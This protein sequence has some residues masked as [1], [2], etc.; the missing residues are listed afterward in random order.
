MDVSS[1]PTGPT[2]MI[3]RVY[4]GAPVTTGYRVSSIK[5]EK[6]GENEAFPV[7]RVRTLAQ[8]SAGCR[9][10]GG[11]FGHMCETPTGAIL[12]PQSLS[13]RAGP[14]STEYLKASKQAFGQDTGLYLDMLKS[15][16]KTKRG[17]M[18]GIMYTPVA[19]SARLVATP[20]WF[21]RDVVFVS[22]ELASTI[23]FCAHAVSKDG[24]PEATYR[25]RSL[26]R[27]DKVMVERP[28][29]LSYFNDQPMTVDF[30]SNQTIGIHPAAFV[31][32][33]GD[34]D[35]D[36]AHIYPL[37]SPAAL[38]ECSRW[39]VPDFPDFVKGRDTLAKTI[40][41]TIPM[42][43]EDDAKFLEYTTLSS[44]QLASGCDELAAGPV[45]RMKTPH[46]HDMRNRFAAEAAEMDFVRQSIRGV[47]D[48]TRQQL[49]QSPV[50]DMTRVAKVAG[51]CVYRDVAGDVRVVRSSDTVV[52]RRS[53][54]VDSGSP[55]VRA[56]MSMCAVA[57]QAMLDAH[58]VR[59]AT[60]GSH[61]FI[62][63]MFL[64]NSKKRGTEQHVTAVLLTTDVPVSVIEELRPTWHTR[65]KDFVLA[66][67]PES[68][69]GKNQ[70]AYVLGTYN[71]V[72]LAKAEAL[73]K[74][75]F[76]CCLTMIRV[77]CVYYGAE[78]SEEEI[79]DL[80]SALTYDVS[81]STAPITS[82]AGVVCR[83][84]GWIERLLAT[85]YS[86]MGL[87]HGAWE[88]PETS[89]AAMFCANFKNIANRSGQDVIG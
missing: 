4:D 68:A 64:G 65:S 55:V 25:E 46:V 88:S 30:W 20:A 34:Y 67:A 62:S 48:I 31:R 72:I 37:T 87:F 9:E 39:I 79:E 40:P 75:I 52:L 57:Q 3:R 66:I 38:E 19:G 59:Q 32:F 41:V 33:H 74:D 81:A 27:G 12:P 2:V 5:L 86:K 42:A 47:G 45:S 26:R 29:P 84:L 80:A 44:C 50:G 69:F 78:V 21:R 28:P 53:T 49:S 35:G 6:F 58:R 51:M 63:D 36:E 23:R 61:D 70:L 10:H 14:I 76:H 8:Y 22:K 13:M 43:L 54:G 56:I 60:S 73:G 83:N 15:T 1:A 24:T 16:N 85:D 7:T 17:H 18:R 11:C 89:T 71:P 77:V 82:R